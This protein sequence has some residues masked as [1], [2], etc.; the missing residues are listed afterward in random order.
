MATWVDHKMKNKIYYITQ[1]FQNS[2]TM[3]EWLDGLVDVE[4]VDGKKIKVEAF[5]IEHVHYDNT[6]WTL[7][8]SIWAKKSKEKRKV[9]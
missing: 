3:T 1:H 8:I 4:E 9:R 2:P 7:L 5:K 6:G